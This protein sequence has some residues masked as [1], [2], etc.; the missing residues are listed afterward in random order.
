MRR[1]STPCV[2]ANMSADNLSQDPVAMSRLLSAEA[3]IAEVA[4]VW[5]LGGHVCST[6]RTVV[7]M[8]P[9]TLLDFWLL[10]PTA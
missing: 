8:C 2:A 4:P 3:S 9:R 1:E 7:W 5:N 6:E 10:T